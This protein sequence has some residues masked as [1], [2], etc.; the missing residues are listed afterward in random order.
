MSIRSSI[1]TK[2]AGAAYILHSEK[3]S[4]QRRQ[5]RLFLRRVSVTKEWFYERLKARGVVLLPRKYTIH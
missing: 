3:D 1:T 2:G 5:E 4:A